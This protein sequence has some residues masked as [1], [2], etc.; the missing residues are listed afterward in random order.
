MAHALHSARALETGRL[1]NKVIHRDIHRLT[2]TLQQQF[3]L[4]NKVWTSLKRRRFVLSHTELAPVRHPN[5][6][7][8]S[9]FSRAYRFEPHFRNLRKG[10][11]EVL[12]KQRRRHMRVGAE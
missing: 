4:A 2:Q 12:P 10:R 3:T 1:F 6:A 8:L 11:V 7:G 9:K 5:F